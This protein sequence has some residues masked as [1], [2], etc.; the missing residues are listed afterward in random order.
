MQGQQCQLH[1]LEEISFCAVVFPT[2]KTVYNFSGVV[3][4]RSLSHMWR[5][6]KQSVLD[7]DGKVLHRQES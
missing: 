3:R 5:F 6:N 7:G 1:L 2:N 4:V